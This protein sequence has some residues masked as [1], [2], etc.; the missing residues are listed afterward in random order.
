VRRFVR[1]LCLRCFAFPA[2]RPDLG[3]CLHFLSAILS[4][5][6]AVNWQDVLTTTFTTV[7]GAGVALAAGT[8]LLK[9]SLAHWMT[10]DAEKFKAQLKSDADS[11]IERLKHSLQIAALEHQVKFSNLHERRANVI[12]EVYQRLVEVYE[13]SRKFT[14]T[15]G[16]STNSS[17]SFEHYNKAYTSN[18]ELFLFVQPRRIYLPREVCSLLDECLQ[19]MNRAVIDANM[20]SKPLFSD[21]QMVKERGVVFRDAYIAIAEDV[22]KIRELLEAE[23]RK[24]LGEAPTNLGI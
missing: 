6:M 4:P 7:G 17:E 2:L 19:V 5:R 10:R 13:E 12:A 15:A 1:R 9:S 14:L 20:S 8:Y 24:I 18:Y 21:P 16:Q 3:G 23:F 11:E 22:P